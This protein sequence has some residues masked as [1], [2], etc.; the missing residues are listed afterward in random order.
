MSQLQTQRTISLRDLNWDAVDSYAQS[1]GFKD[2]SPY[3]EYCIAKDMHKQR[4]RNF[5]GVMMLLLL[6]LIMVLVSYIS[7][8][9]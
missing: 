7:L 4:Y 2:R 8:R 3:V 6:C 1:H 5:Y 9:I